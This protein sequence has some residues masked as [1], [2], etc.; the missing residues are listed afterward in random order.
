MYTLVRTS[1]RMCTNVMSSRSFTRQ[2][3]KQ[4]VRGRIDVSAEIERNDKVIA[5][6]Y[7]TSCSVRKLFSHSEGGR[8]V[9]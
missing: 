5:G 4:E 8:N 1:I 6:C 9:A 3:L 7:F 2:F